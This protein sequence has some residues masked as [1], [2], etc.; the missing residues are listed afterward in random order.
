MRGD[1]VVAV[2][3]DMAVEP[4]WCQALVEH[5]P[6]ADRAGLIIAEELLSSIGGGVIDNHH[7]EFGSFSFWTDGKA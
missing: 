2:C 5:H 6:Q 3:G 7:L 4:L 1:P